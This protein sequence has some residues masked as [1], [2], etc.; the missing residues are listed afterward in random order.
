MLGGAEGGS[1]VGLQEQHPQTSWPSSRSRNHKLASSSEGV[2]KAQTSASSVLLE[3]TAQTLPGVS[4]RSKDTLLKTD[5]KPLDSRTTFACKQEQAEG[6]RR[7]RSWEGDLHPQIRLTGSRL[8]LGILQP[9]PRG[10][11]RTHSF[12]PQRSITLAFLILR[13]KYNI[14]LF[15][16]WLPFGQEQGRTGQSCAWRR[17]S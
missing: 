8:T 4:H 10:L 9:K 2:C 16:R 6:W 15:C 3:K 13:K 17:W 12:S 5:G 1:Q 11:L 14:R 7:K